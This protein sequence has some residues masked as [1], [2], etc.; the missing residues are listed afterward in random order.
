M[1]KPTAVVIGDIHFTISSLE[2]ATTATKMAISKAKELGV[3]VILNGDVLDSKAIIRAEVA[4][5]LISILKEE[6]SKNIIINTGNHDLCNE[7]G[8]ESALNFLEPYA[9]VVRS[10]VWIESVKAYVI[11]YQSDVE[12]FELI[13]SNCIAGSILIVHQGVRGANLGHYVQ[14][15]SALESN[16]FDGFN[17]IGSHYHSH[18]TIKCGRTG[19][20]IYVGSPYTMSFGEANDPVKGFLVL[21]SDGSFE[22][23]LT[24]LRRHVVWE[25][26]LEEITSRYHNVVNTPG[27]DDKIWIKLRGTRTELDSLNKAELGEELFGHSNFKLDKIYVENEHIEPPA[28][29]SNPREAFDYIIDLTP[30]SLEQKQYLKQLY[31]EL[32]K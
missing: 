29:F 24:N 13:L 20:F 5:R 7:K 1:R 11:P 22:R 18:Q 3:P 8:Q 2:L 15:K 10:P 28:K 32:L 9:Q 31:M 6:D 23:I 16:I 12:T 25:T 17:V 19:T 27:P 14:D 30:E 21:Y 4:N 26:S